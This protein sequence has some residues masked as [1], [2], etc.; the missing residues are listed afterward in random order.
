MKLMGE[1][2]A[3]SL[4]ALWVLCFLILIA[5]VLFS[6]L[7]Y[8]AEAG[9][10]PVAGQLTPAQRER[11]IAECAASNDGFSLEYGLCCD[12]N[13]S[14][15]DFPS[16]IHACWWSVVTMTTVGFGDIY[17]RTW[18]GRLVGTGA[19]LMGILIIALPVAIVGRKFQEVYDNYVA[20]A[21]RGQLGDV[22]MNMHRQRH[23]SSGLNLDHIEV[24]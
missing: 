3:N 16:I 12:E 13:G 20:E 18:Q 7:V 6:S 17:P 23:G 1:A 19:M 5:V 8:Y 11:Y 10:C 24:Q 22:V 15:A 14:P 4:Q 2:L 9:S 21:E